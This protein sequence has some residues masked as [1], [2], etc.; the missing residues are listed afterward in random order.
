M[1][2]GGHGLR[3]ALRRDARGAEVCSGIAH[4]PVD[5]VEFACLLGKFDARQLRDRRVTRRVGG[6]RFEGRF[7]CLAGAG[8]PG[9]VGGTGESSLAADFE[10]DPSAFRHQASLSAA[11]RWAWAT[12]LAEDLG[13][14]LGSG[15]AK[16]SGSGWVNPPAW[17]MARPTVTARPRRPG[18]R[19]DSVSQR[20]EL[21]KATHRVPKV[22]SCWKA[23]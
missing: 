23:S 6:Q 10:V 13:L 21:R 20:V 11:L 4:E 7:W 5:D 8:P 12:G 3:F 9:P 22:T 1:L 15:S 18:C 16:R 2:G 17:A 19:W 14:G